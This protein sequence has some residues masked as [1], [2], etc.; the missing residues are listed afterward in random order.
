MN[1]VCIIVGHGKSKSGGYDSGAVS[2]IYHEFKIAKE[3]AKECVDYLNANYD[4]KADLMNYEGDLY[5]T[6]SILSWLKGQ[7][8]MLIICMKDTSYID[9]ED[10]HEYIVSYE[11]EKIIIEEF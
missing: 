1:K 8:K 9:M 10:M 5:L 6:D 7:R 2:G 4:I 11:N 3:I